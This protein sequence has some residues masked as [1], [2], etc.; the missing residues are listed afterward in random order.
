MNASKKNVSKYFGKLDILQR[1]KATIKPE[2]YKRLFSEL[3]K[4]E[5]ARNTIS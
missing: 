4:A 2:E 3:A 1:V 5:N